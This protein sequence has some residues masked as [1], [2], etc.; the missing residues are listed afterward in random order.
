MDGHVACVRE[1]RI[2][3]REKPG[4]MRPLGRP[5]HRWENITILQ[6]YNTSWR[7][8]MGRLEL[9]SSGSGKLQMADSCECDN[10]CSG[11]IK[12]REFVA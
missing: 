5:R 1:K 3:H 6:Y 12:C 2:A 10:E 7:N 4:I 8:V 9:G 11:F